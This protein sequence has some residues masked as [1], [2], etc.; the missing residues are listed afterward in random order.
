MIDRILEFSLRQRT[1]VLLASFVLLSVGLWSA[2]RLPLDAVPDITNPQVQINTAVAA[3]APEEIEKQVTFPIENEMSGI[4]DMVELRSLSKAGLSQVTMIFK[5]GT[6][7][8]RARQLVSER[9][10]QVKDELPPGLT[11]KLAPISTGLGEIFYYA[12]DYRADAPK[13]PATRR[14]QLM[15]L[16]LLQDYVIKPRLRQTPGVAEVNTSG[17]YEKI[18]VVQPDPARLVSLGLTMSDLANKLAENTRNAGGGLVEIGGEQVAI[19]A[20]S[21]AA[22]IEDLARVPLKFG[23]GAQ[24]VLVGDV[25]EITI[26]SSY[27]TGASTDMGEEAIIGAA[28][29][30]AGENSRLVSR[31]VAAKLAEIQGKL[32]AG[33]EL[34][35]LYDRSQ[36]V[37]RTIATV[38]KNLAEGAVL[39][40]VVLFLLLGNIRGACIV[41]LAIPL[42]MLFAMIGMVE[43]NIPG[44]LMSL[45]AIDFGLII[46]GAVVMVENIL[47][48]L[49]AKQH[50]LGRTLTVEERAHEV[51][52]AAK[53]VAGPMFYGVVII[54]MVYVPILALQGI[55][56]KMFKPMALVVM[57]ALGGALVLALTLMPVLCSLLL[58]GKIKEEDNW[59]VQAAKRVYAPVLDFSLRRRWVVVLPMVALFGFS[60]WQFTRLGAE[61]IPQLDEGDGV[62]QLVKTQSTGLQA[63]LEMQKRSERVLLAEFPEIKRIFSRMGAAEIAT[64]PMDP[65]DADTYVMLKPRAEWRKENGGPIEKE[66]LMELMQQKLAQK[67]PGQAALINQPI[68]MRF[69]EIMAG[70]RAEL[71]C[72]IFGE[73]YATLEKLAAEVRELIEKVRGAGDVELDKVGRTPQIEIAPDRAALRRYNLHADDVNRTVEAALAGAP[74]GFLQEGSRRFPVVVRLPDDKRADVEALRQ[75][76]V[77]TDSGGLL[78]LGRVATITSREQI[79]AIMRENAQRRVGILVNVRGRDTAGFVE[80]AQAR[81]RAQVKFPDGYYFEFGGQFKNLIEAKQRL[82]IVVPMALVLIFVIIFFALGSVRQVLLV[83]TGI[84]LAITG[85]VLALWVRGMPFTISAGVGFIALSGVAVLN[86]LILLTC[87]NQLRE[88]GR[89][90]RDA[91]REGA[92]LR[93]RPVLMTALV[94][95]LGF[96][97]MAIATGAGAE[98]QR[99][100]ATVVIGG[101]IT[102]TFLTLV[103][104]PALYSA[105]EKNK[106]PSVSSQ[107]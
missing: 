83:Y 11:P 22:S 49:G 64:D 106:S 4:P 26:G 61:F 37:N 7:L 65:G 54:T 88:R 38:E 98:V 90:V 55:E 33:V 32:P 21:R 42:S 68:A 8:Y 75:L 48:H 14:A 28:I 86:G 91:V 29:M 77:A 47:R 99:P 46:D 23:L 44:N 59:L 73:D 41:A 69:D 30:M 53:E 15:E 2:L 62:L 79:G 93:L 17:G 87:F 63:G 3:L 52:A 95:S 43:L 94:A 25:A 45:G 57:L 74:V 67:V 82:A 13:K 101:I 89:T 31:A 18:F 105:F 70:A 100:I 35:T 97:P 24:P 92:L 56:G 5:D 60:A 6:D 19:R 16:K 84:P 103:L 9:L 1:F 85:G 78:S 66:K 104:L 51:L 20:N 27:R 10:Q 81:I 102:A 96:V 36:L 72:K 58:G 76:P 39:V 80:E 40:V 50:K 71:V 34:R 107:P 12:V